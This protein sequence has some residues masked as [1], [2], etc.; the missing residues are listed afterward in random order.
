VTGA[1]LPV[2]TSTAKALARAIPRLPL[3]RREAKTHNREAFRHYEDLAS[4]LK[5]D[6]H[7]LE[8]ELRQIDNDLNAVNLFY[9][10]ERGSQ[11]REAKRRRLQRYRDQQR[12]VDRRLEDLV[13]S[14]SWQHKL[15]RSQFVPARYRLDWPTNP[16]ADEMDATLARWRE[17]EEGGDGPVPIDEPD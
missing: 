7:D 1:E 16:R 12:C 2:V 8:L 6:D 14:E 15:W 13:S 5:D 4:W 10:G 11:R 3:A 17:P 9:S